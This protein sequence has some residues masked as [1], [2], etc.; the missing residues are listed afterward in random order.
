MLKPEE[1]QGVSKRKH[2]DFQFTEEEYN[3]FFKNARLTK[4]EKQV[5][6]LRRKEETITAIAFKLGTCESNVNKIIRKIKNK[7]I[8]C[9][10]LG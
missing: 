2:W 6:T 1:L 5:L 8:K 4:L 7:I 9:I 3:Y 10:V